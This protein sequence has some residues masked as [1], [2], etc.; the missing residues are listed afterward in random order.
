[1]GGSKAVD[2]TSRLASVARLTPHAVVLCDPAGRIDWVN[3]GFTAMTGY[4]FDE[5]KGRTLAQALRS[6]EGD[7]ETWA[8]I[9]AAAAVGEGNDG[10]VAYIGMTQHCIADHRR[11]VDETTTAAFAVGEVEDAPRDRLVDFLAGHQP[12][13][14]HR[15]FARENLA[16]LRRQR[17]RRVSALVLEHVP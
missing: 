4:E 17:I 3:D 15:R 6:P 1:M 14:R 16:F 5:V 9:D 12:D 13:A 2:L 11:V 8:M 10:D 7:P